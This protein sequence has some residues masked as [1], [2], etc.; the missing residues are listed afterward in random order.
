M[1]F[2]DSLLRSLNLMHIQIGDY[3][4]RDFKPDDA[5]A[6][7]KYAD[8]PKIAANLRDAF[9]S[10]YRKSDAESFLSMV[11]RQSVRT[12]LPCS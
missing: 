5:S 4:V 3:Q 6:L 8:N 1:T 12:A 11:C 10:P 7:A 2:V 9:P